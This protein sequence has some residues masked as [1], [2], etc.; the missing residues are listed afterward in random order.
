M[1]KFEVLGSGP[2]LNNDFPIFRYADVLLMR[3]EATW[4]LG[5]T[6]GIGICQSGT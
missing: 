3:A 6:T 4:R 1:N 2:D 5:E